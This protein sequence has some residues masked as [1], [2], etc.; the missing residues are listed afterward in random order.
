MALLSF[1]CMVSF[2]GFHLPDISPVFAMRR[3]GGGRGL[4]GGGNRDRLM[5]WDTN[6]ERDIAKENF[7]SLIHFT[8]CL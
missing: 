8:L 2:L 1:F 6:I 7:K 5:G 4:G 3:T